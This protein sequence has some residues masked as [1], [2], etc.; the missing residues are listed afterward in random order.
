MGLFYFCMSVI[1]FFAVWF[2]MSAYLDAAEKIRLSKVSWAKR[3][4]L[5]KVKDDAFPAYILI[6]LCLSIAWPVTITIAAASG[7]V[8]GVSKLIKPF[9]L[10]RIYEPFTNFLIRI[11][12]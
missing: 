1:T 2:F 3:D 12:K 8:W 4:F 9:F 11:I 7:I 6:I 10:Q 5:K